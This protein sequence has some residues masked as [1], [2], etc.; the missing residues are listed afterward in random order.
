MSAPSPHSPADAGSDCPADAGSDCPADAAPAHTAAPAQAA[1]PR[2]PAAGLGAAVWAALGIV[3]VVWGSTYLAIRVVVETMPPLLSGALR[4]GAAALLLAAGLAARRGW[5]SLRVTW[6]Q[7]GSAFLVGVL[8]LV[9]GNGMVVLAERTVPS[10]LAAL[11]VA[12]V[13]LWVVVL[14]RA[15]GTRTGGRTLAGVLLGLLGLV[16][17]TAPGLTGQVGLSGLLLVMVAAVVWALGSVLAGRL[18]MPADPFAASVY[19]MLAGALGALA[20]SFLRGE[21]GG[22]DPAAVSAGSWAGLAYLVLFGSIVAFTSYAWL[23]QRAPLPLVATYAYVNPVVAV[24]LGWLFLSEALT[25]PILVGGAVVVGG[26]FLV[27]RSER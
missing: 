15:F 9:G 10:G 12:S 22:F 26:V 5:R 13:P 2:K 16:V 14:R 24:F 3:Y 23:L 1:V 11:L 8:L 20:L 7:F 17:L 27:A 4:F 19:E 18:P 25:W 6:P 21:P